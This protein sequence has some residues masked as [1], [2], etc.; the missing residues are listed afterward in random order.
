MIKKTLVD[1]AAIVRVARSGGAELSTAELEKVAFALVAFVDKLEAASEY[2]KANI[3]EAEFGFSS[4]KDDEN[5]RTDLESEGW[6]PDDFTDDEIARITNKAARSD[7]DYWTAL[8]S[9][10]FAVK[11]DA[12]RLVD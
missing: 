1:Y 12:V 6:S 11:P 7:V 2:D 9:A 8:E 10:V 3:C 4:D 5:T